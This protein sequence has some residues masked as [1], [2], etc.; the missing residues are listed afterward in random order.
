MKNI[1]YIL[2]LYIVINNHLTYAE[3]STDASENNEVS[4]Y[5]SD[6]IQPLITPDGHGGAYVAWLDN[7]LQYYRLAFVNRITGNGN[8]AWPKDSP[9]NIAFNTQRLLKL[10]ADNAGNAYIAWEEYGM[11][12]EYLLMAT[13]IDSNGNTLWENDVIQVSDYQFY[14]I[15]AD[16]CSDEEGNVVVTWE[17]NVVHSEFSHNIVYRQKISSSG[18]KQWGWFGTEVGR[19]YTYNRL[20][21]RL[22][23]DGENGVIIT[24]ADGDSLYARRYS[25]EG[26][27]L[28]GWRRVTVVTRPA[29]PYVAHIVSD[30]RGGAII[31]WEDER[32][33]EYT[34]LYA[35]RL[36]PQGALLWENEGDGIRV[37]LSDDSKYNIKMISDGNGGAIIAWLAS[38]PDY[39]FEPTILCQRINANGERLWGENG[40]Y[41]RS[42]DF[43]QRDYDMTSDGEQGVILAWSAL[44]D[45]VATT[46]ETNIWAHRLNADG[47]KV[48]GA[49]PLAVCTHPA[50]QYRP[51]ICSA[52]TGGS[53]IAW[54]DLRSD[55]GD[56]YAQYIENIGVLGKDEKPPTIDH[57]PP[58]N[59]EEQQSIPIQATI[60]DDLTGVDRVTFSVN[61]GDVQAIDTVIALVKYSLS[62]DIYTGTIPANLVT[63]TG[64]RY[65]IRAFDKKGLAS[66]AGPF[67]PFVHYSSFES[68]EILPAAQYQLVSFPGEPDISAVSLLAHNFGPYNDEEWRVFQYNPAIPNYIEYNNPSFSNIHAGS[69]FWMITKSAWTIDAGAGKS[70]RLDVDHN[71]ELSKGWNIIS[72]T[73]NF[74]IPWSSVRRDT[75][76]ASALWMYVNGEYM[77]ATMLQPWHAYFLYAKEGCSI[78]ISP[79]LSDLKKKTRPADAA[80]TAHLDWAMK[81]EVQC[82]DFCDRENIVALFSRARDGLDSFDQPEP[83]P[84]PGHSV[85]LYFVHDDDNSDDMNYSMDVKSFFNGKQSWTFIVHSNMKNKRYDV[86]CREIVPSQD[87]GGLYLIDHQADKMI[88]VADHPEYSYLSSAASHRTFTLVATREK[89][90]SCFPEKSTPTHWSLLQNYPNPF[91]NW[92][93]ITYHCPAET[94]IT[95]TIYNYL[96]QKITTLVNAKHEPGEYTTYWDAGEWTSGVYYYR[97]TGNGF[98]AVRKMILLK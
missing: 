73:F 59:V 93:A 75:A 94:I 44:A 14:P 1:V 31:C 18:E 10:V 97:L 71:I 70:A 63:K 34:E 4:A 80:S 92:T 13:K 15:D 24:Y 49:R 62:S 96:G 68:P 26:D 45:S 86:H 9:I 39:D 42:L 88:D 60:T 28:W 17:K 11:Q 61:K 53:I 50:S 21:P 78:D 74:A 95:L 76:C 52:D 82:E 36:S 7:R 3:W 16:L 79:E 90:P 27:T 41:V 98:S 23:L 22:T 69:G 66:S 48:W 51:V 30:N 58:Q 37:S 40:V 8:R 83:P 54:Q 29:Y 25:A 33:G 64:L 91:N 65:S 55:S 87:I 6:Q 46:S 38:S 12:N 89:K 77:H 20:H 5:A 35:Q 85:S 2:I 81:I 57:T 84:S 43:W 67:S 19:S 56:V 47:E 72:S 32:F